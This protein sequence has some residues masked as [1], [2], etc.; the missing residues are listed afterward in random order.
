LSPGCGSPEVHQ[1][2]D[3]QGFRFDGDQDFNNW[4]S[5]M[6]SQGMAAPAAT[7]MASDGRAAN[8]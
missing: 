3:Q 5:F 2:A 8:Q 4:L 7:V 6:V 1:Q